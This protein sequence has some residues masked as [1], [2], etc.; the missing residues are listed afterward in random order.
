MSIKFHMTWWL[1]KSISM[2][3]LF[4]WGWIR[5]LPSSLVKVVGRCAIHEGSLVPS[6]KFT[7]SLWAIYFA[8]LTYKFLDELVSLVAI[9]LKT[10]TTTSRFSFASTLFRLFL[11][12]LFI[13]ERSP[14]YCS[15]PSFTSCFMELRKT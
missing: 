14:N 12:W 6:T 7:I 2:T 1:A 13:M 8:S 4:V 5:C 10:I 9:P 15:F 11:P 3:K